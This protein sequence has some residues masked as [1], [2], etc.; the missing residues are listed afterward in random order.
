MRADL[1]AAAL[2][3][4]ASRRAR[5]AHVPAPVAASTAPARRR[6][7]T[8][9]GAPLRPWTIPNAIG[10]VRLALI[11]VF[12]VLALSTDDGTTRCRA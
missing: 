5:A 11:P 10:F 8:L 12:L 7:E 3:V 9:A 6:R 2:R 4:A 1:L